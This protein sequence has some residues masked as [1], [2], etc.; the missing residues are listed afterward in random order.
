LPPLRGPV[1]VQIPRAGA[2]GQGSLQALGI[3]KT[4]GRVLGQ[5]L[6]HHALQFESSGPAVAAIALRAVLPE[7]TILTQG[8]CRLLEE[9]LD[10]LAANRPS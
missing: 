10:R 7:A 5:T 3:W 6:Q 9:W 1:R 2:G 4:L 8:E